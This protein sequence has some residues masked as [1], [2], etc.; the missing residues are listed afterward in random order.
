MPSPIEQALITLVPTILSLPSELVD[1]STSLLAQSRAK[2]ATLKPEEEIAR[3]FTVCHIATERLKLHLGIDKINA[4]PPVAPRVYKKLYAYLDS[5]LKVTT[6]QRSNA[7]TPRTP[8]HRDALAAAAAKEAELRA[9]TSQQNTPSSIRTRGMTASG[10]GAVKDTPGSVGAR[11][12]PGSLGR[13]PAGVASGGRRSTRLP[14]KTVDASASL[15]SSAAKLSL[16]ER[17]SARGLRAR[18]SLLEEATV[19]D[20]EIGRDEVGAREQ[21][22][23]LPRSGARNGHSGI[24]VDRAGQARE[25]VAAIT[26]AFSMPQAQPH[27]LAGIETVLSVRGWHD[28]ALPPNT[29]SLDSPSLGRKRTRASD[30][31]G[32]VGAAA[33]DPGS[34]ERGRKRRRTDNS[35][36]VATAPPAVPSVDESGNIT[37]QTLPG[38]V[39]ALALYTIFTLKGDAVSGDEYNGAR[40]VCIDAMGQTLVSGE[41]EKERVRSNTAVFLR[42]AHAEG[43]LAME[44][45]LGVQDEVRMRRE[46]ETE[47]AGDDLEM[48]DA[49]AEAEVDED[50][51]LELVADA[52]ARV[53]EEKEEHLSSRRTKSTPSKS[54]RPAKTPLR[55]KEKHA[56]RPPLPQGSENGQGGA[57][58]GVLGKAGLRSG[59]G[60]MF[61]D[62]VDW[63]SEERCHDYEEWESWIRG[64]VDRAEQGTAA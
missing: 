45:A 38:L 49:D 12:T 3:T 8:R 31:G 34:S 13:T 40:D 46:K 44:W 36:Q 5:A 57:D 42:A 47:A 29:Q 53:E 50:E 23:G 64:E 19:L 28:S 26:D 63:L 30:G 9:A 52:E 56:P 62:A 35:Q 55:R 61:Q 11:R 60:T 43:W 6:Q 58:A 59:L 21:Q 4:K 1:L 32:G 22:K 27:I 17:G 51:A 37:P 41:D 54:F 33:A 10:A 15:P 48:N 18:T 39:I 24:L 25:M 14:P 2:A 16:Q 7:G 20:D